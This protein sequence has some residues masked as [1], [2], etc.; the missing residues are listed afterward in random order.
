MF[1]LALLVPARRD[2]WDWVVVWSTAGAALLSLV[3]VL[4]ALWSIR[5]SNSIARN[6]DEALVRERRMTFELGVLAQLAESG[7]Y[8]AGSANVVRALL[9]V[10]PEE[11]MPGLRRA[12]ESGEPTL[13]NADVLADHWEEYKQAVDRRRHPPSITQ[14]RRP[15][16]PQ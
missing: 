12:L 2:F 13:S 15:R 8:R 10:L 11:D 3:A 6:A 16:T 1:I 7:I 14:V 4:C 9:R 5:R